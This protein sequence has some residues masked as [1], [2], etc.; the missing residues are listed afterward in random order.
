[1]S[2]LRFLL[3]TTLVNRKALRSFSSMPP[4]NCQR[5]SGCISVSL[6]MGRS[7]VTSRPALSSA[8][9]W[10]RRSGY[11]RAGAAA[12]L[13]AGFVAG[14]RFGLVI[15]SIWQSSSCRRLYPC[16]VFPQP[17]AQHLAAIALRQLGDEEHLLRHLG[18]RQERLAMRGDRG[19]R[20]RAAGRGDDKA[21]DF[22]AV[23]LVGH[24]DRGRFQDAGMPH[25]HLVDLGRG[26]VH[27]AADDE[28]LGAAGDAHEA[29]LVH[30][31]EVAGLDAVGA[32]ALNRAVIPEI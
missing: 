6:L 26:D 32:N 7:T 2:Y 18:R 29:V 12:G 20:E 31:R 3:S 30:D 11:P 21:H 15:A 25:Q 5:T 19:L 1:M 23:D 10:S 28:V 9:R 27:A 4:R 8:R 22:L 16:V 17:F 24:A 13:P 14:L